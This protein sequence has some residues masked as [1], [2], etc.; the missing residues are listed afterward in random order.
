MKKPYFSIIMPV[1]NAQAYVEKAI[2][3]ILNQTFTEFELLII[4]DKSTDKSIDIIQSIAL[5]DERIRVISFEENKGVSMAR[6]KGMEEASG[7]YIWYMDADDTVDNCLLQEVWESLKKNPARIVLFGVIEEYYD[8]EGKFLYEHKIVPKAGNYKTKKELR[9]EILPLERETLYGYVWN[10][11]YN[12]EYLKSKKSSFVNYED[13]RFIEDILFNIA[14]TNDLPS[15]NVLGIAPYH[16]G[17]RMNENLTNEFAFDYFEN[18]RKRIEALYQQQMDWNRDTKE[19]RGILGGLY[20]R[21]ILSA[22]V[23]N[24]DKR[25]NMTGKERRIFLK[26]LYKEKLFV[27]LIPVASV[28]D[29]KSLRLWVTL[30]KQKRSIPCLLMAKVVYVIRRRLPSTFNKTKSGR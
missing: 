10:K 2:K 20:A 22:M 19:V 8:Q 30:L 13:A 4:D 15:L 17:K 6:N 14:V 1:Y 26:G 7:H 21:Y 11:V 29:S 27:R 9:P 24:L 12:L 16:Y 28:Q 25:R 5:K 23:R 3:S 18:H